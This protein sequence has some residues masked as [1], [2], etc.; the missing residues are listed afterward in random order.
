MR[1]RLKD[2]NVFEGTSLEIVLA[3]KQ[4]AIF[5]S[6]LDV[7]GYIDMVVEKAQEYEGVRLVVVPREKCETTVTRAHQLVDELLRTGL[8]VR[9]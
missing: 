3:M 8:A 7:H 6:T 4:R 2:Q 5:A 1:I 9:A